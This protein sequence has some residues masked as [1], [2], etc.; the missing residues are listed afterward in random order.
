MDSRHN[1][2]SVYIFLTEGVTAIDMGCLFAWCF[3]NA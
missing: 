2:T 1:H 3:S